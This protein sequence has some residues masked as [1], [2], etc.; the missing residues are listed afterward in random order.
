LFVLPALL[1]AS[2]APAAH[3]QVKPLITTQVDESKLVSLKGA[4]SPRIK[5]AKDLGQADTSQPAGR[6]LLILQHSPEQEA[7]LQKFLLQAHQPGSP[8]FHKWLT[9]ASY[10]QQFGIADS[11]IQQLTGWLQAH[12]LTVS[13]VPA[14]KSVIEFTGT[15]GQVQTAFHTSIHTYNVAG[16]THHA[17]ATAPQIPA[18]FSSVVAGVSQLNDFKPQSQVKLA[19]QATYN[20]KTHQGKPGPNWTYPEGTGNPPLYFLAPEDVTTQYDVAPAYAA[21]LTGTGQTIGIIND[22]NIDINLV[23]A[24]RKL[25]NL[26]VNPPQVVV[27]GNDPGVNGDSI[28]AYLDVENAG[29]MAP[30]ATVKLYISGGYGL[31][32]DGGLG[33]SLLR[34]INDDSATALSLSFGVCEASNGQAN[35]LFFNS[36]WEEAAAQGQTVFVSSGDSGSFGC[37]GLGVNGFGSSPW[38]ISVGGTD[39]Y[40][41]DYATGGAS[42]A[43]YWGTN[44]ANLGSLQKTFTEQP[45]NASQFGLNSTV[46][47]PLSYATTVTVGGGGGASSC[48]YSTFDPSTYQTTCISGWPKPSYQAGPGVPNDG[49]RDVPDVSLFASNAI[50]GVIWPVCAQAGDCSETDPSLNE[51]FVTGVGGTSASSPS[52]AG[53]MALINQKYGP[54]G[55]ANFVL[56]PLA[57]QF[58]AAFH[59]ITVGNN[60]EAC[61][62]FTVGVWAGCA[63]DTDGD[64]YYSLQ[65]YY[66]TPGY[67]QASGLGTVDVNQMI[68]HWSSVTFTSSAT[69]LTLSPTT[70]THGATV[71]ATATVT[72]TG[73]PAGAVSVVANTTLPNNKS[74]T[75]IQL[76]A[77]GTGTA[78]LTNLPGGT[79]TVTGN[80]SGDGINAASVSAPVTLTV[81]PEASI[82]AFS[83]QYLDGTTFTPDPIVAGSMVPYN[84]EIVL[85]VQVEGAAGTVDGTPTGSVTFTNGSTILAVVPV[86]AGGTA[87][88]KGDNLPPGPYSIG[89]S[90]TGDASYKAST[91]TPVSFTIVQTSTAGFIAA[92]ATG[93]YNSDGSI[94]YVAGQ[95]ANLEAILYPNGVEGYG[96]CPTGSIT[97][98]LGTGAPVTTPLVPCEFLELGLYSVAN[99]LFPALQAGTYTLTATYPGDANYQPL[100]ITQVIEVAPSTLLPSTT[101]FTVSPSLANIDPSTV[102]TLTATVAGNGT[103]APTGTA[104]VSI[105]NFLSFQPVTLTPAANG[106]AT[107]S[108]SLRASSLLAGPNVIIVS[109]GGD[110][111]YLPSVTSTQ[112]IPDDPTDFTLAAVTP[113]LVIASGSTGSGT[114]TLGSENSFAGAVSLTCTAP[115]ALLC[116]VPTSVTLTAAGSTTSTFTINT[117]TA[118]SATAHNSHQAPLWKGVTAPVLA[119]FLLL[120]LPA[121]KRRFGRVLFALLCSV[122]L[123]AGIMGCSGSQHVT[124]EPVIT[125]QNAAPGTYTVV[126]TGTAANGLI[127][128]QN[129]TVIVQ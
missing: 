20:P 50:N 9:P 126:I 48:V 74:A 12:G 129:I 39:I 76:G 14:N 49:V 10:S 99:D 6:L 123:G 120:V 106:T 32:G 52:M 60:N 25:F 110:T 87:E 24:Y 113:N 96:L 33:F 114:V 83:P 104:T 128:N 91:V 117:V 21:G 75:Y 85:D 111:N 2:V 57:K 18:A 109:Y 72:G 1:L 40:L 51:T 82:L 56:Y 73:T 59:D 80:Y 44:D 102:V 23:N 116:T 81:N 127:H 26:P 94:G 101:T 84:S 55:Q 71:T 13:N 103:I 115:S 92:D 89:A 93:T 46:Y 15:V 7:A 47:D 69:D 121:R 107:A 63:L 30:A 4:V 41:S 68:T 90:Y 88:F 29:A 16:E 31:L 58:P 36:L 3:A 86:S 17:N 43:G 53:I 54:Q 119:A 77:G 62:S 67:D 65:N 22:S 61:Y 38:N 108:I 112:V 95:S 64:G 45:W 78:T 37:N 125:Y 105:A 97:F 122:A 98:T 5:G 66:T 70:F 34:A 8:S 28:E 27:D 19:G 124:K 79:Y 118:I 11:D 35:N 100:T 42:L